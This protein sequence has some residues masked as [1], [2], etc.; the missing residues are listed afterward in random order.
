MCRLLR[1]CTSAGREAASWVW[2]RLKDLTGCQ[3][4]GT[5]CGAERYAV[6]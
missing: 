2:A 3:G 4:T 6:L 5:V 1:L